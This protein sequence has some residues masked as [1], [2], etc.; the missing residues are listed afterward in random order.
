MAAQDWS[1]FLYRDFALA[2]Y[3]KFAVSLATQ[4]QTVAVGWLIY[5]VTGS[6]FALGFLGL[7]GFLPAISLMLVSGLVADRVE[8]RLVLA[9][10]AAAMALAAAGMLW[11]VWTG[12]QVVWPVYLFIAAFAA[13]RSFF[14]PASQAILPNLVPLHHFGQAVAFASGVHQVAT[15]AG[16]AI[17]GLLY[18]VDATL[19]FAFS[20]VC[21]A[22]AAAAMLAVGYRAP[23]QRQPMTWRSLIAGFEFTLKRPVL[24]GAVTLD[25]FAVILASAVALLPIFAKDILQVGPWGLGLLRSAPALGALAMAMAL[26]RTSFM[27]RRAGPRLFLTVACYGLATIGF[28]LSEDFF[29]SLFCLAALGASDM[30]SVVI[31]M[32]IMQA[33][34]PNELRGRVAAVNS[35]FITTSNE[36]GQLEA[37]V[38]AGFI[39]AVPAVVL[40]GAGAIAVAGIWSRLFPSLRTRD[41]LVG[42]ERDW[43]RPEP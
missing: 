40:G 14:Q 36:I 24:L 25:M 3:G 18:A 4:M 10:T 43:A 23:A 41:H 38:L 34:T 15:I 19:P 35:L 12:A 26:S 6:A 13:A 39:G 8:R 5:D 11:H 31:R 42:D 20:V 32:T 9:V 2:C 22:A 30:V 1:P 29:L 16:P 37:G 28:G 7:A 17:G 27:S 21:F 33:E